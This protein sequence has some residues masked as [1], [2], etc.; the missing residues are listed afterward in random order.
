MI[1]LFQCL[2]DA[3]RDGQETEWFLNC[4]RVEKYSDCCPS[5]RLCVTSRPASCWSLASLAV[6]IPISGNGICCPGHVGGQAC[7][8][9][10]LSRSKYSAPAC[11]LMVD[12]E[13]SVTPMIHG[14]TLEMHE[15]SPITLGSCEG[16]D[17]VEAV[18]EGFGCSGFD[19]VHVFAF[20]FACVCTLA[21]ASVSVGGIVIRSSTGIPAVFRPMSR[22]A[23]ILA[24]LARVDVCRA[25]VGR[26]GRAISSLVLVFTFCPFSYLS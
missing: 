8:G 11:L 25:R 1:P 20:P 24:I 14:S 23:T 13:L 5:G 15:S 12:T 10:P 16:Y 2:H 21:F 6:W 7:S 3:E 22:F 17:T 26:A 19:N 9:A 4:T 18:S